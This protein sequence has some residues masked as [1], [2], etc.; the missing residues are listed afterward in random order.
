MSPTVIIPS[1]FS[2]LVTGNAF[3]FCSRMMDHAVLMDSEPLSPFV[4]LSSTSF[5]CTR[6][7]NKS[8]G[9]F[10]PKCSSTYCVSSFSCPALLATWGRPVSLPRRFAYT[11]AEHTE[12]V[13]GFLCPTT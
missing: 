10:T 4:F 8:W 6:K 5:T 9:A 7:S 3:K 2:S 11:I 1:S 13:S 12:S